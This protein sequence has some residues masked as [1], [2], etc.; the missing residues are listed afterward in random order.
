MSLII[1]IIQP[2]RTTNHTTMPIDNT[3]ISSKEH[4]LISGNIIH[5]S[6][7][8]LPNFIILDNHI[9]QKMMKYI[10]EIM[11]SLKKTTY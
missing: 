3:F 6:T 10:S 9:L 2:I 4:H 8:H 1:Q 11:Q 7:D 5:D